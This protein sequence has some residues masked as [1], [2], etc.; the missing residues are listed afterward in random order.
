MRRMK[1]SFSWEN[2]KVLGI[3]VREKSLLNILNNSVYEGVKYMQY[4]N[5]LLIKELRRYEPNVEVKLLDDEEIE[6][7]ID[8]VDYDDSKG[9]VYIKGYLM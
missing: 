7:D 9:V 8:F 4:T 6:L 3:R 2:T 1:K 5:D